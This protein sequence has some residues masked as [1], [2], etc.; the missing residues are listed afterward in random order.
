MFTLVNIR[1]AFKQYHPQVSTD[2]VHLNHK[3]S[4]YVLMLQKYF[5][6]YTNTLPFFYV[7]HN[8]YNKRAC[9]TKNQPQQGISYLE[10]EREG[11]REREGWVG[12]QVSRQAY[13]RFSQVWERQWG[14]TERYKEIRRHRSK[15]TELTNKI[16][17]KAGQP[18]Q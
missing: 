13:L 11:V 4:L 2:N 6:T 9:P 10:R 18:N 17:S 8:L 3:N 5:L 14:E 15:E 7:P 12:E 1:V 16:P